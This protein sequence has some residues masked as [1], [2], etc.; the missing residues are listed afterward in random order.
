MC[1]GREFSEWS[2]LCSPVVSTFFVVHRWKKA[3][4]VINPSLLSNTPTISEGGSKKKKEALSDIVEKADPKFKK[5]KEMKRD[6]KSADDK[7]CKPG[8]NTN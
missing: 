5:T 4:S 6:E 3:G 7:V 8:M 1:L 2:N